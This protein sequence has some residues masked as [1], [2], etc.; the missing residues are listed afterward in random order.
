MPLLHVIN[1][2]LLSVLIYFLPRLPSVVFVPVFCAV[3]SSSQASQ[4]EEL[5]STENCLQKFG[6]MQQTKPYPASGR[7]PQVA[8]FSLNFRGCTKEEKEHTLSQADTPKTC[9]IALILLE[10]KSGVTMVVIWVYIPPPPRPAFSPF[11]SQFLPETLFTSFKQS[12][13]MYKPLSHLQQQIQP[14]EQ[15]SPV[16]WPAHGA[17]SISNQGA[18]S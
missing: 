8:Q 11:L 6:V 14:S 5:N 18:S 13:F 16:A 7:F 3:S 4:L 17:K 15:G 1:F 12:T 9:S 10:I 2:Y